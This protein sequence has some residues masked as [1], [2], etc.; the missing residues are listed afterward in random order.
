MTKGPDPTGVPEVVYSR[1]VVLD[2]RKGKVYGDLAERVEIA[3]DGLTVSVRVRDGLRFHPNKD[4][5][6]SAIT[7]EDVR[8]DFAGRAESGEY[9]F[10]AAVDSIKATDLHMAFLYASSRYSAYVANAVLE[11]PDH[12]EFVKQMTAQYQEM[13]RQNRNVLGPLA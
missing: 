7:A 13:L 4:N 11:V 2:P 5:L 8:R 10:S 1:L 12:E 6:A 9:L 3:P